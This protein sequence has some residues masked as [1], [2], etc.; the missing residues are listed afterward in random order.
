LVIGFWLFFQEKKK[1]KKEEE[2]KE[3]KMQWKGSYSALRM[4]SGDWASMVTF[5]GSSLELKRQ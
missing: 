5:L 1:K 3:K 4:P 2:K